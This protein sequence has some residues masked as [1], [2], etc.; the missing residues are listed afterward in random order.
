M[1]DPV[2]NDSTIVQD[3]WAKD[4]DEKHVPGKFQ[5]ITK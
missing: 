2:V 4:Y 3:G 1:R 5:R